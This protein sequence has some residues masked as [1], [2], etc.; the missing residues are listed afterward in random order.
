MVIKMECSVKRKKYGA[1]LANEFS[2]SF[3]RHTTF[4]ECERKYWYTYYGSWEG[5][6]AY[7]R[8]RRNN[9]DVLAAYLYAMKQAQ[10]MPMFVGSIV[11]QM[12]EGTLKEYQRT[13]VLCELDDLRE[14]GVAAF[15][16]GIEQSRE[17]QWQKSPKEYCNLFEFYYQ[18]RPLDDESIA[19][20]EEKIRR[21]LE[22]WHQSQIVHKLICDDRSS[23]LGIEEL[24][25]FLL[26]ESYKIWVVID[27]AL[28][29]KRKDGKSSVVLFDWKTGAENAL[30]IDQLYSYALFAMKSWKVDF[31]DI[32]LVPFYLK[33]NVY[34]KIGEQQKNSLSLEKVQT[35][36]AF[37][38]NS[39][40]SMVEKLVDSDKQQN[41]ASLSNFPCVSQESRRM[42]G[43]C[44]YK[45]LCQ[46]TDFSFLQEK[47]LR[48][49]VANKL[50][51]L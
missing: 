23:F 47:D 15:R 13:R 49:I 46:A 12:I 41:I 6:Y 22:N 44:S 9:Y 34:E 21:C 14:R 24:D 35:T 51:W 48:E 50:F 2:W 10:N 27:C 42:C 30:T 29:W 43:R 20:E 38:R 40:V 31:N 17:K 7:G 4:V 36:E 19:F 26:D 45:E 11:H 39:C 28:R 32:I 1:V 3:S 8:M 25:S 18:D 33:A 5:W 37:I 16:R